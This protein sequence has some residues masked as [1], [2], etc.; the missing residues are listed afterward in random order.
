VEGN[1]PNWTDPSGYSKLDIWV[2]AFI[3]PDTLDFPVYYAE[4]YPPGT[5]NGYI[6]VIQLPMGAT[7]HGDGRDFY[8]SGGKSKISI[9]ADECVHPSARVCGKIQYD[10]STMSLDFETGTGTTVVTFIDQFTGN[11]RTER[12]K[13]TPPDSNSVT[14]SRWDDDD[15]EVSIRM[16]SSNP[17]A[18][19]SPAIDLSYAIRHLP[20]ESKLEVYAWHDI[21]PWHELYIEL[22]GQM[23]LYVNDAPSGPLPTPADLI[24]PAIMPTLHE[25]YHPGLSNIIVT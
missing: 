22:D 20:C 5:G 12:G 3:K 8:S 23:L 21:F 24:F 2:S 11:P 16:T 25:V 17:L 18:F 19:G 10:L 1:V 15:R 14:L 13:A 6:G 7:W 9:N 4:I